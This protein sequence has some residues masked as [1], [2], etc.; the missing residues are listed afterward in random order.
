MSAKVKT[1]FRVKPEHIAEEWDEGRERD[2]GDG[3]WISLK[4]GWK[5]A[6]D[7]IGALH[8]IHEDTKTKARRELV[9]RCD[10]KN[11][12]ADLVRE[13]KAQS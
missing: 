1:M 6:I 11:C 12:T 10:C 8:S 3:Y 13:G 2:G 9:M 7:P 4:S 5:N